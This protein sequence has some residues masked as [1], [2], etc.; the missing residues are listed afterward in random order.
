MM[1]LVV[2][3]EI[4]EDG[5]TSLKW[6]ACSARMNWLRERRGNLHVAQPDFEAMLS[7]QFTDIVRDGL[8]KGATKR[9]VCRG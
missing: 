9:H 3:F 8:S 1:M 2:G 4:D 5:M 7:H 6:E